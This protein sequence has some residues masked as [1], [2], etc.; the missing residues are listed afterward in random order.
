MDSNNDLGCYYVVVTL[1]ESRIVKH[2]LNIAYLLCHVWFS[3]PWDHNE[4]CE[5]KLLILS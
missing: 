4:K 2:V 1:L 3:F 5:M